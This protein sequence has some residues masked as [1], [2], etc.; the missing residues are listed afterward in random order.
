MSAYANMSHLHV[1]R[2][3]QAL[4]RHVSLTA[5]LPEEG[6]GPFPVVYLLHGMMDDYSTWLRRTALERHAL[7]R[8]LAI[9]LPDGGLSWWRNDS[10][11]GGRYEDLVLETVGYCERTFP[12]TRQRAGRS[13]MGN[14]MG[15]YG[16]LRLGLKYADRFS[17][18]VAF[19]PAVRWGKQ[20]HR[21]DDP[22]AL[23]A[24]VAGAGLMPRLRIECGLDDALVAGNR[25]FHA[26][27]TALS[28]AHEYHER[29]GGHFWDAWDAWL[30][31]A[32]DFVGS[33]SAPRL[34]IKDG[35]AAASVRPNAAKPNAG[36]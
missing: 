5:L 18:V 17:T 6:D 28:F 3:S 24:R 4:G 15:G 7:G 16:A 35:P 20:T 14:S 29:P 31:G 22:P 36:G 23:A 13:I 2:V 11:Y 26:Q 10:E 9:I 25:E 33:A 1:R 12:V 34:G 30:P 8:G 21:D 19:A 32:L 27:L